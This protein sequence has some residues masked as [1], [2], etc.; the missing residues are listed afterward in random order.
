MK[1]L[2]LDLLYIDPG[3]GSFLI[4]M[5]I[6]GLASGFLF[7]SKVK[8]WFLAKIKRFFKK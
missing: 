7:Y 5:I 1:K 2:I 6:A 3:S 4:Q 8:N